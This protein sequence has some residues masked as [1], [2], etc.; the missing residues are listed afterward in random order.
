ME[1]DEIR[2]CSMSEMVLQILQMHMLEEYADHINADKK[3]C[4]VGFFFGWIVD[5][6]LVLS[7]DLLV[8]SS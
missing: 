4:R 3:L 8:E 6:L 2:F 1:A 5:I 7:N